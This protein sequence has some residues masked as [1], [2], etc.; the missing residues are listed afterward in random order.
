MNRS[1]FVWLA[2]FLVV[3]GCAVQE[4]E[5]APGVSDRHEYLTPDLHPGQALSSVRLNDLVRE[6]R[7]RLRAPALRRISSIC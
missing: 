3:S 1:A 6:G 4:R 5:P 2:P 7:Y